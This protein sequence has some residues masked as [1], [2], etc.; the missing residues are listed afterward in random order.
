MMG[1]ETAKAEY[2]SLDRSVRANGEVVVDETRQVT[3]HIRTS[4]WIHKVFADY[5][6]DYVKKGDPLFTFYSPEIFGAEQEYL[7]AFKASKDLGA[8]TIQDVA[9]GGV[10]LLDAARSRLELLDLSDDEIR[11]LERTGK[12]QR[13]TTIY[14]ASAG[15][16][17]D[18]KA[19]P[20]STPRPTWISTSSPT[21][22]PCGCSLKSSSP[23]S[24]LSSLDKKPP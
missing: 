16:V 21:I 4:G 6:Y 2:R 17:I 18:R 14:S 5:T 24:G 8:S 19:L 12:P 23:T 3:I 13:E 15:H 9:L 20:G 10:N 22:Q 7:L 1:V 11:E